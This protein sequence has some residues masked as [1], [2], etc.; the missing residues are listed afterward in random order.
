T[1]HKAE[2]CD[3]PKHHADK[4]PANLSRSRE[5]LHKDVA[6]QLPP[7]VRTHGL[8]VDLLPKF[9]VED[10]NFASEQ[11]KMQQYVGVHDKEQQRPE[12]EESCE[13]KI[14][15]EERQLDRLLKEQVGVAY[16]PGSDREI[17]KHE[18]IAE[19]KARPHSGRIHHR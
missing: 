1:N 7:K 14:Y 11:N 16:A 15:A 4:S 12:D 18:E 9:G 5:E 13:G 3:K 17:E 6:R 2:L 19:P 8:V 10:A